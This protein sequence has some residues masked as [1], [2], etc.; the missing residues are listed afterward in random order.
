LI[1]FI[2]LGSR[3]SGCN[4]KSLII[5]ERKIHIEQFGKCSKNTKY[6]EYRLYSCKFCVEDLTCSV[7]SQ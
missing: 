6:E 4:L 2:E 7:Y 3:S 1:D 5:K